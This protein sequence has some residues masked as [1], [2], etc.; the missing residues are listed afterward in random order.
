MKKSICSGSAMALLFCVRALAMDGVQL[1]NQ[2]TVMDAGGFPYNI[3]QSGSY[4]LSGNLVASGSAIPLNGINIAADNV[5]L[6]LNGFTI[7]CT[8]AT[9]SF[10]NGVAISGQNASILNGTITGFSGTGGGTGIFYKPGSSGRVDHVTVSGNIDGIDSFG[11]M[12]V[13]NSTVTGNP[14]GGI[15]AGAGVLTVMNCLIANNGS[16]VTADQEGVSGASVMNNLILGNTSTGIGLA[17]GGY[18]LNTL[19]GNTPDVI[20]FSSVSMGNNVCDSTTC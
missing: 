10:A 9:N 19:L 6:D 13:T 3:T 12:V 14:N 18:G 8:C 17:L 7:S 5:T 1:I 20:L 15:S 2:S 11:T 16:G 4:K